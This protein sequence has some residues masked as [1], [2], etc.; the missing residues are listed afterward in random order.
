MDVSNCD[1]SHICPPTV[2]SRD[3]RCALRALPL[4]LFRT[5]TGDG[6]WAI[7]RVDRRHALMLTCD[8]ILWRH[9]VDVQT[10]SADIH[11]EIFWR[12]LCMAS[13]PNVWLPLLY[14]H[15]HVMLVGP[16][17]HWGRMHIST[18]HCHS[19]LPA[20]LCMLHIT[21]WILSTFIYTLTQYKV[22]LLAFLWWFVHLHVGTFAIPYTLLFIWSLL[23]LHIIWLTFYI[24]TPYIYLQYL[25]WCKVLISIFIHFYILWGYALLST[26]EDFYF[27]GYSVCCL[28]VPYLG[29]RDRLRAPS[30][31]IPYVLLTSSM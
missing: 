2:W 11:G 4:S 19:L 20:H 1:N 27:V 7:E 24:L 17:V 31:T 26:L 21:L 10:I 18:P 9:H 28:Q 13:A 14:C 25:L 30:W 23:S 29:S 15:A 12:H 8:I 5:P 6:T 22:I 3:L 16:C